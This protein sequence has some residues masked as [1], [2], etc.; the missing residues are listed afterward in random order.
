MIVRAAT[1]ADTE[2]ILAIYAPY[3]VD[4]AITYETAVPTLESFRKRIAGIIARYPYLVAESD[5][6]ILGFAYA[7]TF[8]DRRAYDCSAETSIYI[9]REAHGRGIG[10]QLYNELERCV[11][12]NGI[13]NLYACIAYTEHEDE[14]L[15]NDSVRFHEHMGYGLCGTFHGCAVKFGRRYDM[16]WMEKHLTTED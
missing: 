7:S 8:K 15:T 10:R 14:Y 6:S 4:T 5:G 1:L 12:A 13:T 9:A 16:V 3:I 2:A 11:K